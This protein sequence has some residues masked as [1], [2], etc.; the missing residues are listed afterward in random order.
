LNAAHDRAI[1]GLL[2]RDKGRGTGHAG[3]EDDCK[4]KAVMA[5]G[6]P[7]EESEWIAATQPQEL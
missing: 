3:N 7:H 5:H 2:L 4:S 6:W 1:D